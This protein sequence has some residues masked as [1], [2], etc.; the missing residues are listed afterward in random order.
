MTETAP[1]RHHDRPPAGEPGMVKDPVCGMTINPQKTPHHGD[2]QAQTYYFCCTGCRTKFT[3]DPQHYLGEETTA[4]APMPPKPMFEGAIYT[5]PMHPQIR[6]VG[7]GSCP[8]CGMA[9]GEAAK[10]TPYN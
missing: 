5:C 10:G 3:A 4:P 7:P 8:I 2:Y 6:Q 1:H 9:G